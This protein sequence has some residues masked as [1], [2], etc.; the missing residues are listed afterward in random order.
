MSSRG[1]RSGLLI[2]AF[3]FTVVRFCLAGV[4]CLPLRAD[5]LI[6]DTGAAIIPS[7]ADL[8][9]PLEMWFVVGIGIRSCLEVA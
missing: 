3:A 6:T 9:I 1:N 5:G 2:V 8:S 4:G 7:D